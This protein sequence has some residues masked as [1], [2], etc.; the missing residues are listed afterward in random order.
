[1]PQKNK[2]KMSFISI[3]LLSIGLAMDC[4]AVSMSKGVC[5][6]HFKVKKVFRMALLFGLFQALMPL[7]GYFGASAVTVYISSYDHWIAFGLLSIIGV[8]LFLEGFKP[9]TINCEKSHHNS[10]KWK[11]L[12]P[13]AIATSIDALAA[14]VVLAAFPDTFWQSILMIGIISFFMSYMGVLLGLQFRNRINFRFEFLGG[15]ILVGIGLK[16][17]FEHTLFV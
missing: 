9:Q 7:I 8:K 1:V 12:L 14:G 4:F 2:T 15:L 11:R 17:L 10:F 5:L 13:L 16:I 3:I 6:S